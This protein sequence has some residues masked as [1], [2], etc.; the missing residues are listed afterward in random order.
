MSKAIWIGIYIATIVFAALGT[1][2]VDGTFLAFAPKE[3]L[4]K[5]LSWIRHD[6]DHATLFSGR[7]NG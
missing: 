5:L 7:F 4:P 3:N 1:D 6:E 2:T